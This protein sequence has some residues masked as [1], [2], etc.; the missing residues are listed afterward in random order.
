LTGLLNMR[1]FSLI[2]QQEI[3]KAA[4]YSYP[5][6]V[7][8]IDVDNLKK[9]NDHH[10]HG[11]GSR[12][13]TAIA[14]TLKNCIRSCDV[15]ARYGGDEFVILM[16]QT[17]TMDASIAAERIRKAVDSTSFELQGK[18]IA[19]T[20]SIGYASYPY[21][22]DEAGSVFEKADIALYTSKRTGRNRVTCYD[23]ELEVTTAC[24]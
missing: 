4:R 20:I 3:A 7:L 17:N 2:L 19:S 13:V 18:R 10:G 8:M 14:A 1:T 9:V 12:L 11:A 24:A 22:V 16:P 23:R 21:C 15:L 6:T 5:F